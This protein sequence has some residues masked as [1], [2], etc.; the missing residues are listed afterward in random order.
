MS[1]I[2]IAAILVALGLVAI[3]IDRGKKGDKPTKP[4]GPT[5]PPPPT[6]SYGLQPSLGYIEVYAGEPASVN[7]TTLRLQSDAAP[8]PAVEASIQ[9][10]V[11]ESPA[12][13][14]ASPDSGMCNLVSA[15]SIPHPKVCA[16]LNV[17]AIASVAGRVVAQTN[18]QVRILPL[19]ELELKWEDPQQSAVEVDGKEVL[20]G[21]KVIATP[22]D[23]DNPPDFLARKIAVS[24]QGANKEW[25]R[26]PLKPYIQYEKQWNP[27]SAV[28]PAPGALLSPGNP[29]LVAQF[30]GGRQPLTARLPIELNA[31]PEL[32]AWAAGKKLSDVRYIEV[33]DPPGWSFGELTVYF[34]PPQ[35]D[36]KPMVP[37]FNSDIKSP[38]FTVEPADILEITDY[39]ENGDV[40]GTY[41]A[42]VS[43]KD[44]V[45]LEK[46]F[47]KDLTEQKAQLQ[48]TVK[49]T[50]ETGKV[51]TSTVTYQICPTVELVIFQGNENGSVKAD[52]HTYK[53]NELT[54]LQFVADAEDKLVITA[55][56]RRTDWPSDSSLVVPFGTLSQA[57]LEGK[58]NSEFNLGITDLEDETK[59][60]PF[61][62]VPETPGRW[63][64]FV[65]SKKPLLYTADRRST[66]LS[67]GVTG[68]LKDAP[69]NYRAKNTISSTTA[70]SAKQEL[71]P[72]YLYLKLWVIPGKQRETSTV[73]ALTI[74]VK[75]DGS[76]IIAPK[77]TFTEIGQIERGGN[78]PD[79]SRIVSSSTPK[80]KKTQFEAMM[81]APDGDLFREPITYPLE[82]KVISEGPNI[83]T[84]LLD[85]LDI[86]QELTNPCPAWLTAWKLWYKGLNW[87]TVIPVNTARFTVMCRIGDSDEAATFHVD[88]GANLKAMWADFESARP[89]LDLD[90]PEIHGDSPILWLLAVRRELFGWWYDLRNLIIRPLVYGPLPSDDPWEKYLCSA[91]TQRILRYFVPRRMGVNNPET[92]LKMNG[93]EFLGYGVYLPGGIGYHSWAGMYLSGSDPLKDAIYMDPWWNQEWDD[94]ASKFDYGYKKQLTKFTLTAVL[95]SV[96]IVLIGR[97]LIAAFQLRPGLI[98]NPP[99]FEEVMIWLKNILK[100]FA[101]WMAG[102]LTGEQFLLSIDKNHEWMG[103]F[104]G[105]SRYDNNN[106]LRLFEYFTNELLGKPLPPINPEKW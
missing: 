17:L 20:A 99:T 92:A 73:G 65:M 45:D 58:L 62:P 31:E 102:V 5:P 43:L 77:Y 3:L 84:H 52:K 74:I 29:E 1:A 4:A 12:G 69:P 8:A 22:P 70:L 89:S 23:P 44:G 19:F 71:T 39:R 85:K 25:I 46:I 15:F 32:G 95:L 24:V 21:A 93:I 59:L 105:E 68:E 90:N 76:V 36:N 27:I 103:I 57:T 16:T 60:D 81:N 91:L 26:Q 51:Y 79:G 87:D 11:P 9:V 41:R 28:A 54:G 96:E 75:A 35:D 94:D 80:A 78:A 37:A 42:Q 47:G 18:V 50:A 53:D 34:H 13:L 61:V 49:V 2:I 14:V 7:F 82:L 64:T 104:Q 98:L 106:E 30:A 6:I 63:Y 83:E 101:K 100:D 56:L 55:Y 48:L 97:A 38:E 66:K 40:P 86:G 10:I 88:V 67:L 72:L 33:T